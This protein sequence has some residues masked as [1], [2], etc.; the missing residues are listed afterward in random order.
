MSADYL[1]RFHNSGAESDA[2]AA[3]KPPSPARKA[4]IHHRIISCRAYS[5]GIV[6]AS[7]RS[8]RASSLYPSEKLADDLAR[9]GNDRRRQVE[10]IQDQSQKLVSPASRGGLAS[11]Q[12]FGGAAAQPAA[13]RVGKLIHQRAMPFHSEGPCCLLFPHGLR[14]FHNLLIAREFNN[15][16]LGSGRIN[17]SFPRLDNQM[18]LP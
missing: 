7:A 18:R 15:V 4:M 9:G 5:S 17:I 6:R 10:R 11:I 14:S 2:G 1:A 12:E 8:W 16:K 13:V 3:R